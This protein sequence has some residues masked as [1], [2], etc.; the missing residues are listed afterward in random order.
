MGCTQKER[1][2][3]LVHLQG[4]LLCANALRSCHKG[5]YIAEESVRGFQQRQALAAW[6]SSL[7]NYMFLSLRKKRFVHNISL[8]ACLCG[9]AY[10]YG[11]AKLCSQSCFDVCGGACSALL[12]QSKCSNQLLSDLT[13]HTRPDAQISNCTCFQSTALTFGHA[14]HAGYCAAS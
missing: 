4:A 9:N 5:L 10:I 12:V 6:H 2:A 11:N 13:K 8:L 1:R 7:D 14:V 3:V